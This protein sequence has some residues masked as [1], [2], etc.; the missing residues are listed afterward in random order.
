MCGRYSITASPEA[1][2][3]LFR[4]VNPV[5]NLPPRYNAAPT[6]RLPVVRRDREGKG[7]L[8][9]L[10]WGLVPS[11]ANEPEIGYRMINARAESVADRP[12]YRAAFRRRR[13]LVPADG[14]YEW[15]RRSGR[16]Q[17]YRVTMKDG[18]LFA[19]AGLWERW[20]GGDEPLETFTIIVTGA[21]DLIRGIH[22]RMPVI[23]DPADYEAWLEA[24][25]TTIPMALLQPYP[26]EKMRAYPVGPRVN[27]PKN[28]DPQVIAEM[29]PEAV[30]RPADL[31]ERE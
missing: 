11:W 31:F 10:R 23:I 5:P 2:R 22:E 8:A 26:A 20:N 4:F 15:Q 27:S 18:G 24:V 16:K 25:D 19:F 29:E 14:F 7:E 13:C 30:S 12:A 1:M 9:L 28:D 17:P 3:R 6:Q 21:N